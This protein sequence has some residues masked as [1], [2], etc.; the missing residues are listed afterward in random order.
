MKFIL[1]TID[2]LLLVPVVIFLAY[3]FVPELLPFTIFASIGGAI[4]FVAVKYQLVY[5]S[6]K[7]GSHYLYDLAGTRCK[8]VE[9]VTSTSGRVKVGA[10]IWQ[11]RS[12]GSQIPAGTEAEIVSRES[13]R[14]FVKPYN[15]NE[16]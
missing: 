4:I 16:N 10:E 8:V 15:P 5:D 9:T 3:Y 2:E 13:L 7:E 14:V 11:A 1:I 12:D 6:L